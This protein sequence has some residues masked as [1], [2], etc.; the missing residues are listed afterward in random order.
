MS[1]LY[2]APRAR[3]SCT[4]FTFILTWIDAGV[5]TCDQE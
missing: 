2:H 1:D 5:E 3:I 4:N